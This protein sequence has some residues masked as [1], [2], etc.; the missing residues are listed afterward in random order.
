MNIFIT[1]PDTAS[2]VLDNSLMRPVGYSLMLLL[3]PNVVVFIQA[4]MC[5]VIFKLIHSLT[6]SL[7]TVIIL[8][9]MGAYWIYVP[10]LLSD[11]PFAF[12]VIVSF[13]FLVQKKFWWHLVFIGMASLFK[14]TIAWYFIIEPLMIWFVFRDIKLAV[15]SFFLCF[16]VTSAMPLK[17]F[18]DHGI[19]THSQIL[20]LSINEYYFAD[21]DNKP[22]YMIYSLFSNAVS[23]HWNYFFSIFGYHKGVSRELWFNLIN[24]A[25]AVIYS[26]IWIR[27]LIKSVME[28][29]Y[30]KLIF[31]GYFMAPTIFCHSGG[32]RWRLPFEFL[33]L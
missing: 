3:N 9:L 17:N 2:Y 31:V 4:V 32:G 24:W 27:F 22:L 5:A 20:K 26:I 21:A 30:Y 25:F 23:T 12:F 18:I 19:W 6:K 16:I 15:L 8:V 10:Y 28:K 1:A 14:S 13:Y 11:L 7:W 29:E 33:L